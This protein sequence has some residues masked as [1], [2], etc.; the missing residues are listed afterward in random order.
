MLLIV[1]NRKPKKT[2]KF[3]ISAI[4]S[5]AKRFQETSNNNNNKRFNLS[6]TLLFISTIIRK[7]TAVYAIQSKIETAGHEITRDFSAFALIGFDT[8]IRN[9]IGSIFCQKLDL[10]PYFEYGSD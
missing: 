3:K 8:R 6:P 9:Q 5:E 1:L 4:N 10:D 2:Q 7:T